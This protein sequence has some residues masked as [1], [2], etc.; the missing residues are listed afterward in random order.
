M[1]RFHDAIVVLR[2]N[3]MDDAA[4]FL[5]RYRNQQFRPDGTPYAGYDLTDDEIKSLDQKPRQV[6]KPPQAERSTEINFGKWEESHPIPRGYARCWIS[7]PSLATHASAPKQI[8]R[9]LKHIAD[10]WPAMLPACIDF[11][12]DW[13]KG[14]GGL[15]PYY[16]VWT[17]QH[18]Y[19]MHV[20]EI[21]NIIGSSA[22]EFRMFGEDDA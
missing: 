1:D 8:D 13:K 10:H 18:L 14:D 20:S 12:L 17:R 9:A 22:G 4:D 5:M 15:Y 19:S 6:P 21:I 16:R 3:R 11:V 2:S 7:A